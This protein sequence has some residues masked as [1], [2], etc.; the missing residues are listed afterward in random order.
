MSR[1]IKNVLIIKLG[2]LGDFVLA[3]AAVDR[4]R[5]SHPDAHISLLTTPPFEALARSS[6]YFDSVFAD[7]RPERFADWI[8]LVGRLRAARFDRVYDLQTN[9]RSNFLFQTLRPWAP[10]WS[11]IAPGCSHPHRSRDRD[12]MHTLERQAEQLLD[13]GIWPDAPIRPGTASP[14]DLSW[15]LTRGSGNPTGLARSDKPSAL[16][17]PGGSAHRLD[18]RWPVER[19]AELARDLTTRGLDVLILGGSQETPLARQILKVAPAARDLTARTDFVQLAT[20]GATAALAVGNDTGPLH[21]VA[22]AGAPT[23]ALFS[24][25]SDPLLTAP[26]GRVTV[27]NSQSLEDLPLLPVLTAIDSLT[28][29]PTAPGAA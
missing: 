29:L 19:F 24:G 22:A 4:I 18:K 17:V 3:M 12:Q 9:S 6:P 16:L 26:R 7:G 27:V 8:R 20:L 14:P 11:G 5:K 23:V 13:A 2:A 21:L 10:E 25:A 1:P 28:V 15:L